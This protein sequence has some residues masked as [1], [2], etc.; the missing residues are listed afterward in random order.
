MPIIAEQ[1]SSYAAGLR[2]DNLPPEVVHQASGGELLPGAAKC[3]IDWTT[4]GGHAPKVR[5]ASTT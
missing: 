4:G 3:T 1:L 5:W 2:Y